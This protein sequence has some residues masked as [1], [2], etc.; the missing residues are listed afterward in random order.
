MTGNKCRGKN[1]YRLRNQVDEL[2]NVQDKIEAKPN[3][4]NRGPRTTHQAPK[5]GL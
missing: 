2:P 5:S 4:Y 1:T 3:L